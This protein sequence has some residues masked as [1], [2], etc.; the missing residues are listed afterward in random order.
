MDEN[1][2]FRLGLDV[3]PFNDDVAQEAEADRAQ[4]SWQ[5]RGVW[6]EAWGEV[7]E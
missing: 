7:P 2:R 5:F 3:G 4:H 1:S 6:V